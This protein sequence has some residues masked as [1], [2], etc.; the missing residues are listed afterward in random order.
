MEDRTPSGHDDRKGAPRKQPI[1]QCIYCGV[2][3]KDFAELSRE[4]ILP[5]GLSGEDTLL[6]ASCKKCAGI[7]AEIERVCIRESLWALRSATGHKSGLKIPDS[8]HYG[9]FPSLLPPSILYGF[10][11]RQ[12]TTFKIHS[13]KGQFIE[14]VPGQATIAKSQFTFSVNLF[15]RFLCKVAHG[16]CVKRFGY[17]SFEPLLPPIILGE[18]T[19]TPDIFEY[20]GGWYRGEEAGQPHYLALHTLMVDGYCFLGVTLRLFVQAKLPTYHLIVG[21]PNQDILH[22]LPQCFLY[23][24]FLTQYPITSAQGEQLT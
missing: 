14:D 24:D 20:V 10:G 11:N 1:G 13:V 17:G 15:C 22:A 8:E 9:V 16:Y 3:P 23:P 4:H 21:R 12:H 6:R 7:T 5:Q 2:T 18:V 19:H